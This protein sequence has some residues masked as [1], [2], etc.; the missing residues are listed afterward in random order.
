M[1]TPQRL[2]Y[3]D[4]VKG[5]EMFDELKVPTIALV[6]NMAYYKCGSCSEKHRIFGEGFN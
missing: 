6:E 4:V 3:V 5:I 2:S 1:T